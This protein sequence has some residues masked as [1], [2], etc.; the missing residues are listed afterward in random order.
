M[1]FCRD[2]K[3]CRDLRTFWET[4]GKKSAILGQK[5]CFYEQEVHEIHG[6]YCIL[7]AITKTVVPILPSPKD[8]QLL[9]PWYKLLFTYSLTHSFSLQCEWKDQQ[10]NCFE[11]Q[12]L[13]IHDYLDLYDKIHEFPNCGNLRVQST[14]TLDLH[15]LKSHHDIWDDRH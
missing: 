12:A 9:P 1:L 4:L 10:V 3:I 2:I 7:F 13:N 11:F 15:G 6:T 14:V 8:C 5:Q